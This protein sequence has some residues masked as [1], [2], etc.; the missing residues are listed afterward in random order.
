MVVIELFATLRDRYGKRVEV[1]GRTI[2]EVVRKAC[3]TFGD[4]FYNEVFDENGRIRDDRIVL[5]NGRNLKDLK[6]MPELNED[7]RISIFPPIAGGQYFILSMS[8]PE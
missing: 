5:V 2:E 7:D 6:D 3:E 1:E 4:E 8:S